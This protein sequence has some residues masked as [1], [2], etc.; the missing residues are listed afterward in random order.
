MVNKMENITLDKIIE[1]DNLYKGQMINY[2]TFI[3]MYKEYENSITIIEFAKL[4]GISGSNLRNIRRTK[5]EA[6]ILNNIKLTDDSIENIRKSIVKQYEGNTIYYKDENKKNGK[7]N[8]LEL[9][10]PYR[11]Y[12]SENEFAKILGI[13]EKNLWYTKNSKANPKIKDIEKIKKVEKLEKEVEE[14]FYCNRLE[15]E[16]LCKKFD[17]SIE[18]FITYYINKGEFFDHTV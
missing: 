3:S 18:D 8:F 10:R 6:K 12:F 14:T 15:L 13:S 1:R 11:I 7:I 5:Q 16:K 2:K 9:Y 17:L 4:I